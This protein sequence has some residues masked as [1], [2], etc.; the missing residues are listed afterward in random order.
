MPQFPLRHWLERMVTR[1]PNWQRTDFSKWQRTRP[2]VEIL[3]SRWV[4]ST[5]T[6]LNDAGVGSL[7]QAILDTPAGGTVDFQP[8][9][10][11]TIVLT[12]G[13]LAITHDLTIIGPGADRITVSGNR[14]SRIFGINDA[15][16][17]VAISALT[18]AGGSAPASYGGGIV[19]IGT[20]TVSNSII[21][22]NSAIGVGGGIYNGG[23][24]TV[25]NSAFNGNSTGLFGGGI[26]NGGTLTVNSSTLSG[27]SA[28]G[29]GG[30]IYN[31]GFGIVT[32][33]NSTLSNNSTSYG[34]GGINNY[35][36]ILTVSNSTLS[37]NSALGNGGGIC[38][39]RT[40]TCE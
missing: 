1:R 7:R 34:G 38:N 37:G 30:G 25:S 32:V 14:L 17:T 11:G 6:N 18:I 29:G 16:S 24:L 4:P 12:S 31:E 19:N 35:L 40:L 2:S 8:G 27:N 5:V 20:L 39:F 13:E 28:N 23:L 26:D 22:D 15:H 9:L 33:S 21:S 36:G 3:E 10:T